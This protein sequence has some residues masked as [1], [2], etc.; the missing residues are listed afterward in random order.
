[1]MSALSFSSMVAVAQLSAEFWG[2][3]GRRSPE[4]AMPT[5][6]GMGLSRAIDQLSRSEPV[7]SKS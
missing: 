4:V 2:T 6:L 3:R 7:D 1:M 5:V